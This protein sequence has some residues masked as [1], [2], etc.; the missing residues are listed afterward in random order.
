M[1]VNRAAKSGKPSRECSS[2]WVKLTLAI[3]FLR[4]CRRSTKKGE[5]KNFNPLGAVESSLNSRFRQRQAIIARVSGFY[6]AIT[7]PR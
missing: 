5:Q 4:I 2:I 7:R 6:W 3:L 1:S